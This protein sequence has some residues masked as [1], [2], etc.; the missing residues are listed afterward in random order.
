MLCSYSDCGTD[1]GQTGRGR[2]RLLPL[3]GRLQDRLLLRAEK[4]ADG[5]RGSAFLSRRAMWPP[6]GSRSMHWAGN[7]SAR[8]SEPVAGRCHSR[9][10]PLPTCLREAAE[11]APAGPVRRPQTLTLVPPGRGLQTSAWNRTEIYIELA[12][13]Q[14]LPDAAHQRLLLLLGRRAGRLES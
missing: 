14:L 11:A 2:L 12:A 6:T 5:M 3:P 7:C 10:R 1:R 4:T 13:L 8:G 9:R